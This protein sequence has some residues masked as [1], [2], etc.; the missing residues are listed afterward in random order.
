MRHMMVRFKVHKDKVDTTKKVIVEFVDAV[1]E[2]EPATILYQ[3]YQ[4]HQDEC[5]FVHFMI[6]ESEEAQTIHRKS[7]YVKKFVQ[8]L[9][10]L[11][12]GEPVFTNLG[13]VSRNQPF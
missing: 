12:D 1:K 13:L 2:N 5:S 8:L 11:C 4:E 10:P 3:S 6:F 7:S 9:Y